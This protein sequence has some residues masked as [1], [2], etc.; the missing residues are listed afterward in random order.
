M[1]KIENFNKKE[2]DE[3]EIYSADLRAS[4]Q[5]K[6]KFA[7]KISDKSKSS[8]EEAKKPVVEWSKLPL[9]DRIRG[10]MFRKEKFKKNE[11]T[12]E[13]EQIPNDF[14]ANNL[15]PK[16]ETDMS[17]RHYYVYKHEQENKLFFFRMGE[18]KEGKEAYFLEYCINLGR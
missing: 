16:G 9:E 18:D 11:Q 15:V 7:E 10:I 4:Y 3:A 1:G 17:L 2:D 12:G 8:G 14:E 13:T 6:D 5:E